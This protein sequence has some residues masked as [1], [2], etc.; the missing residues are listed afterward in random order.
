MVTQPPQ[1][2][3]PKTNAFSVGTEKTVPGQALVLEMQYLS[4][5]SQTGAP[6]L[7]TNVTLY[8]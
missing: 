1:F 4:K 6:T 3:A 5:L 8:R 2:L 7:V